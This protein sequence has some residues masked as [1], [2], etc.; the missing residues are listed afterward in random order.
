MLEDDSDIT[1]GVL[2]LSFFVV[3]GI[4]QLLGISQGLLFLYIVLFKRKPVKS[5]KVG[6]DQKLFLAYYLLLILGLIY[7]DNQASGRMVLEKSL[8]FISCTILFITIQN[9]GLRFKLNKVLLGF[10]IAILLML[11]YALL[12]N[13]TEFISTDSLYVMVG[14]TRYNQFLYYGLTH[15]LA[16]G[17]PVYL[18]F[19][20]VVCNLCLLYKNVYKQ[21][22]RPRRI[23][24]VL[25][26]MTLVFLVLL[27]SVAALM[28]FL[29]CSLIIIVLGAS[30]SIKFYALLLYTVFGITLLYNPKLQQKLKPVF[31]KELSP[32]DDPEKRNT[33][34]I[35]L[36]KW[37][38]ATKVIGDNW[39]L[40]TGTGDDF[41]V[42]RSCYSEKNYQYLY[43][44]YSN[45]HNQYLHAWVR[46]GIFGMLVFVGMLLLPLKMGKIKMFA[47]FALPIAIS[48]ISES[49]LE[50]QSGISFFAL[51]F[52][53]FYNE[54]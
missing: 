30:K 5:W 45:P 10:H 19:Y 2:L 6:W 17:H 1:I 3:L 11:L 49:F 7:S 39:L 32:T 37:D 38:C 21:K 48:S 27:Q 52:L 9:F 18:S 51:F 29:F 25:F 44:M 13:T 34:T 22:L 4:P 36:A 24:V 33:L 42:L 15:N 23:E 8:S 28:A 47:T 31:D 43:A 46:N 14:K 16:N 40:G 41:D 26:F 53:L 50:L 35:R 12:L 54:E 20:L